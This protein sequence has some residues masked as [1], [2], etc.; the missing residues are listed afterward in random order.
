MEILINPFFASHINN[1][2]ARLVEKAKV[3]RVSQISSDW[4]NEDVF[5]LDNGVVLISCWYNGIHYRMGETLQLEYEEGT[6]FLRVTQEDGS[7][8]TF[9]HLNG[10]SYI[11]N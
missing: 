1:S 10:N 5:I 4:E 3:I 7:C 11:K 8:E 2:F 9:Q 6:R